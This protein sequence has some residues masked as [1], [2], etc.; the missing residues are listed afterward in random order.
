M[1]GLALRF[2]MAMML[3]GMWVVLSGAEGS[4]FGTEEGECTAL[5]EQGCLAD[6]A[7]KAVY[8]FPEDWYMYRGHEDCGGARCIVPPDVFLECV[9]QDADPCA[10]LEEI[11]C[12]Q[13][14]NDCQPEYAQCV[15][16]Q[17]CPG[18][19]GCGPVDPPKPHKGCLDDSGCGEGERCEIS[20]TDTICEGECISEEK[21]HCDSDDDCAEGFYCERYRCPDCSFC[22]PGTWMSYDPLQCVSTYWEADYDYQPGIYDH[23]MAY[24]DD[25]EQGDDDEDDDNYCGGGFVERCMVETFLGHMG[26]NTHDLRRVVWEEDVCDNCEI[27]P[28]GYSIY[29][30][31]APYDVAD[32][33]KF[34]FKTY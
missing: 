32:M 9:A 8:G 34:G 21:I 30:L 5:D 11:E 6:E 18:Y 26:V 27:C 17:D 23:C 15:S 13:R 31:V 14:P 25:D 1:R 24:C 19:L 7:C 22:E 10:G 12:L 2:F 3:M 16:G 4:C 29:T 33:Q 28:R 20:C